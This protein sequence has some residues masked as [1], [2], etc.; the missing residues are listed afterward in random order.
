MSGEV[1]RSDFMNFLATRGIQTSIHYPPIP[2]F[3]YYK[4][5]WPQGFDHQLPMTEDVAA[6]EVTLPLYPLMTN[7]QLL[8]VV[9]TIRRFFG[10]KA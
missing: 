1:N 4:Q 5:L 3:S 2:T 10:K 8:E 9:K 6:R 7:D